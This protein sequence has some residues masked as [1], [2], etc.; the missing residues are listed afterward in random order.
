MPQ[1]LVTLAAATERMALRVNNNPVRADKFKNSS[2]KLQLAACACLHSIGTLKD[3]LG[4]VCA[5]R[6]QSL[7]SM[8]SMTGGV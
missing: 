1:D 7:H 3:G 6:S 4:K 8:N 2:A 5:T